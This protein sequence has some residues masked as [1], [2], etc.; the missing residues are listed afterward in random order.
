[1]PLNGNV[2]A[3]E[4]VQSFDLMDENLI[5]NQMVVNLEWLLL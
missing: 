1:M 2:M 3:H 4:R 5:K